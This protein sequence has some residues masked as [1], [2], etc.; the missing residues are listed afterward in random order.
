[1]LSKIAAA[2]SQHSV[3][4]RE[5]SAGWSVDRAICI[6][7]EGVDKRSHRTEI[8]APG[9]FTAS[10]H[11]PRRRI[12]FH[13]KHDPSDTSNNLSPL[14]QNESNPTSFRSSV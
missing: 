3:T 4:A 11:V 14:P 2:A 8:L 13:V 5:H 12:M 9:P 10:M 6:P 7:D 1:M